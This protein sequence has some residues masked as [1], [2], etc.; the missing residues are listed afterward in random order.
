LAYR[1]V[2]PVEKHWFSYF[3]VYLFQINEQRNE[4]TAKRIQSPLSVD[5]NVQ[6][7]GFL[8][9][10]EVESA[11]FKGNAKTEVKGCG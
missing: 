11:K 10:H 9:Q 3:R 1:E 8:P 7:R 4:I 2:P 6:A 5:T